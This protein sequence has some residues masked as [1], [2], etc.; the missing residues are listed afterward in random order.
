MTSNSSPKRNR[1]IPAALFIACV[2]FALSLCLPPAPAVAAEARLTFLHMN[3]THGHILP[4]IDKSVDPRNNVSG[5]EYFS[6]LI[7]AERTEN[8]SGTV[9]LSAGDMFQ[10]TPISNLFRGEPV[11][12]VMNY[13]KFDAMALGNHEFDWGQDALGAIISHARFPILSSNVFRKGGGHIEGVK[14]WIMIKRQN[15]RIAVIGATTPS[16]P[17]ASNPRNLKGLSF[18]S[19][20]KV[21]PALIR[22]ARAKGADMIVVLSHLG[23]DADRKLAERVGGIDIIVGG[24]SHTAV[25]EP[26]LA[27]G[28]II[29]QAGCNGVYLG[30][31]AIS[32][33]TAKRKITSYSQRDV[34]R[35]VSE[36]SGAS[37]DPVVA[38]IV[39]KYESQVR[40]EFSR[41]VGTASVD[42]SRSAAKESNL[43]D[44]IT[45][46]M[47][48]ASGAQI[49]FHNGGGIRT[50]IAKGPITL[51][52]IYTVLPFD[53]V[54]VSM[55]ITGGQIMEVLEK[56]ILGEKILQVSGIQVEYDLAKPAGARVVSV[57]VE[58]RPLDAGVSYRIA[59]NDFL[60]AGGDQYNPFKLGRGV[61]FGETI[62]EV[63]SDYIS[64]H[65]PVAT[66]TQGRIIFRK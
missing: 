44:L 27:S 21:L 62:R 53:N 17:Y 19:P 43:G 15:V 29:V 26:V 56:S 3:D 47:R 50:D 33:D 9:L 8:P 57:Q 14:P 23:L 11:I 46:A 42:L 59:T 16:T 4:Y 34:L 51:E 52:Q 12:E 18:A 6:K 2:L 10:G 61:L 60:A 58:G 1:S 13:L 66:A 64:K 38:K 40:T 35:L 65:S 49:A 48:D 41:V 30:R 31:L 20:E 22:K 55:E 25:H 63:V 28:T 7:E 45:D 32:F 37:F 54:L 36:A 24:H 5:A 39:E